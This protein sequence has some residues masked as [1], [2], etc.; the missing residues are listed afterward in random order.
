VGLFQTS[1][2]RAAATRPFNVP[3]AV[4]HALDFFI[5]S[6]LDDHVLTPTGP[7]T[8][9]D[10]ERFYNA[11]LNKHLG[12]GLASTAIQTE[13]RFP[14]GPREHRQHVPYY[15]PDE[16]FVITSAVAKDLLV[17]QQFANR[18]ERLR[19]TAKV[20]G[21]PIEGPPELPSGDVFVNAEAYPEY[22]R[23]TREQGLQFASALPQHREAVTVIAPMAA[24]ITANTEDQSRVLFDE[25]WVRLTRAG[26]AGAKRLIG[27]CL[28][29]EA[30]LL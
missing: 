27:D 26:L 3:R 14:P 22:F 11:V 6:A 24:V 7:R 19:D 4:V 18:H 25:G 29:P 13:M 15:Y 8:F 12:N 17:I 2:R 9:G 23:M 30:I 1:R 21:I 10:D 28:D 16:D 5:W 20:F